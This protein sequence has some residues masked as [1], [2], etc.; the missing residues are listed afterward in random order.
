MKKRLIKCVAGTLA[1]SLLLSWVCPIYADDIEDAKQQKEQM[2]AELK[3]TESALSNLEK[4]KED[5]QSYIDA[6]DGY[7]T[8]LTANIYS[9][10]KDVKSK[11]DEIKEK[12]KEIKSKQKEI[13]S[14]YDAMKLR[15]KYMY[16]TGDVSFVQM[17]L[18][19]EDFSEFLNKAEY[20]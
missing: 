4:V 10:E 20:R 3:D 13:D 12:K 6:A 19:S 8:E 1:V 16:E 15:I 18:E 9:L 11:K 5:T 2:E 7:I 14:Q 17:F